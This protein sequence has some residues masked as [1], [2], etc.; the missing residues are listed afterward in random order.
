MQ[1]G[2]HHSVQQKCP[3][4]CWGAG[5]ASKVL[6]KY[7]DSEH[8]GEAEPG[9]SALE[10]DTAGPGLRAEFQAKERMSSLMSTHGHTHTLSHALEKGEFCWHQAYARCSIN[11]PQR[12]VVELTFQA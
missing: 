4:G 1:M 6:C 8:I 7:E 3:P 5:S 11:A 12:F 2:A 9:V 10:V